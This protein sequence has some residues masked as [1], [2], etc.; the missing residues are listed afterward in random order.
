[1]QPVTRILFSFCSRCCD[2]VR[3]LIA[4]GHPTA[5]DHGEFRRLADRAIR[6][7]EALAESVQSRAATEDEIV[8]V[9]HLR[10]EEAVLAPML[11]LARCKEWREGGQPFLTAALQIARGEGIGHFL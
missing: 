1:M 2:C 3:P 10:E 8:T 6:V 7:E 4:F 5:K 9:F 11:A